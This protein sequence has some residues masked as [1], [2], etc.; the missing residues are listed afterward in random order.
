[1]IYQYKWKA[2]AEMPAR[3]TGILSPLSL[4]WILIVASS[5]TLHAADLVRV[6]A[7]TNKIVMFYLD[8]GHIDYAGINQNYYNAQVFYENELNVNAVSVNTNFLI[9]SPD[10]SNYSTIKNPTNV[11]RKSKGTEFANYFAP[12]PQQ[13]ILSHWIYIELPIAMMVGKT[14]TFELKN[15]TDNR[16][17][18]NLVFN[19][20][21]IISPTI[22][23]NQIGFNTKG[24]KIAYLSQW[25]GDFNASPHFKGALDLTAFDNASFHVVRVKDK[26][27]VFTGSVALRKTK[28]NPD[29][30]RVYN[31]SNQGWNNTNFTRADVYECD[32]SAFT[33]SGEYFITVK[34]MGSSFPFII[35]NDGY[36]DAFYTTAKGLFAQR[37]GVDKQLDDG[38]IYPR[39]HHPDDGYSIRVNNTNLNV[40]GWY[41]DAGDWDGY[42]RHFLVPMYLGLIYELNPHAFADGDLQ[43]VYRLSNDSPWIREGTNGIPDILDEM[44]WLVK[45]YRRTKEQLID[46]GLG[47]GGVMGG[48]IGPDAVDWG[49]PSWQD[50]R[51]GAASGQNAKMTHYYAAVA[52]YYALGLKIAGQP[53]SHVQE[54]Q[55]QAIEAYNW[56]NNNGPNP[57]AKAIAAACLYRL[58]GV[59]SYQIDLMGYY[60]AV[61]TDRNSDYWMRPTDLQVALCVYA[62]TK[63][64]NVD[65]NFKSTVTSWITSGADVNWV[66]PSE[67]RGYRFGFNLNRFNGTGDFT[68]KMMLVALAHKLTGDPKYLHVISAAADYILGGNEENM[69]WL[70]GIGENPD[71]HVF[72]PDSWCLYDYNSKVYT[73]PIL[74]GMIPYGPLANCDWFGCG[75]QWTG[76]EDFNRS[77]ASGGVLNWPDAET[78]FQNRAS[79]PA[80]EFTIEDQHGSY[81]LTLGYLLGVSPGN[82]YVRNEPP[83]LSLNL[84]DGQEVPANST[85]TLSVKASEDTRRVVY[86]YDW[87]YIGESTNPA[88]NFAFNWKPNQ[89]PGTSN[90]LITA[91]AYDDQGLISVPT[92]EGDKLINISANQEI[93]AA[94]VSLSPTKLEVLVDATATL[95]ATITPWNTTNKNLNWFSNNTT[96]ATVNGSGVITGVTAGIATISVTTQDG[97]LSAS[98]EV[99][100]KNV[101]PGTVSTSNRLNQKQIIRV[102]PNP[103]RDQ[104]NIEL[105][106]IPNHNIAML[107]IYNSLGQNVLT[108]HLKLNVSATSYTISTTLLPP[109]VYWLHLL[110][111]NELSVQ[112]VLLQ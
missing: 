85:L 96:I 106:S 41:H 31:G 8:D 28:G 91:V 62:L 26:A 97:K 46:K 20:K 71:Q 74:P 90:L 30:Y 95:T 5:S 23:V 49:T 88:G 4:S 81:L 47:T 73:N 109:G 98:A 38:V 50:K 9:S 52:A 60:N 56:A 21:D 102:F 40:W 82:R 63:E 11:G 45:Y 112:Q 77:T 66:V 2:K 104:I 70:T 34:G 36:R 67:M 75:V 6:Q 92:N 53:T 59:A 84:S 79:I 37:Q 64:N 19:E 87:H 94:G 39:D 51:P 25:M 3:T 24:R 35:S 29:T 33:V 83:T 101:N 65:A 1:M 100:V 69:V 61:A 54:W 99:S 48:Y 107:T 7:V 27:T 111:G 22:H 86:Y 43:N 110:I 14:Y 44:S 13:F 55:N 15:I 108:K 72:H 16:T 76:D 78:R 58:T 10:D 57:G 103:G 93:A 18:I 42:E 32:F 105:K 17:I 89:A 80:N 12:A 68:P